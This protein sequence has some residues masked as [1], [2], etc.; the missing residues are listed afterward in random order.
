VRIAI[1]PD[2]RILA[3]T[4]TGDLLRVDPRLGTKTP[5]ASDPGLLDLRDVEIDPVSGDAIVINAGSNNLWS[6]D[7]T[8]GTDYEPEFG[9]R[10]PPSTG[11]RAVGAPLPS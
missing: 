9:P 5:L 11:P 4:N 7:R 8:T 6:V 3:A 10:S 2:G 1:E